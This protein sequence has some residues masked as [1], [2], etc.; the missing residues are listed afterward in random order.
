MS[1]IEIDIDE[2]GHEGALVECCEHGEI[3][4]RLSWVINNTDY[5]YALDCEEC[6]KAVA[7]RV[8]DEWRLI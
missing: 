7:W 3:W 5:L 8:G 6:G 1:A 4:A 2:H